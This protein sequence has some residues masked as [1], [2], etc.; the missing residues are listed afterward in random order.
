MSRMGHTA[1]RQHYQQYNVTISGKNME[2]T[3]WKIMEI[4]VWDMVWL[5]IIVLFGY[6]IVTLVMVIITPSVIDRARG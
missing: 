6:P 3:G 2:V 5:S 1:H 4:L